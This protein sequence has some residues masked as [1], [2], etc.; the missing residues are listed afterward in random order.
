MKNPRRPS[1]P[2]VPSHIMPPLIPHLTEEA[3]REITWPHAIKGRRP[4]QVLSLQLSEG[5]HNRE[6]PTPDI[7]S[8]SGTVGVNAFD[9]KLDKL[10]ASDVKTVR[11]AEMTAICDLFTE[12]VNK[13]TQGIEPIFDEKLLTPVSQFSAWGDG[14]KERHPFTWMQITIGET[15]NNQ[16]MPTPDIIT[17]NGTIGGTGYGISLDLLYE[18]EL[19]SKLKAQMLAIVALFVAKILTS[20]KSV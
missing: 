17:L 20:I 6:L 16:R 13:A 18:E 15:P 14:I 5:P 7:I 1:V 10:Y 4:F 11:K 12:Q 2:S 8:L 9:L 19:K 3:F